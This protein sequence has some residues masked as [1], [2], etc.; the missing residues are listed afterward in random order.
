MSYRQ[1]SS[2]LNNA[3]MFFEDLPTSLNDFLFTQNVFVFSI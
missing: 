2:A 3:N 1:F